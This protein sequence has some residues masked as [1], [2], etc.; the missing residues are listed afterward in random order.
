VPRQSGFLSGT[1]GDFVVSIGAVGKSP[2]TRLRRIFELFERLAGTGAL[3]GAR[4][5]PGRS[6]IQ[7]G[8]LV[9]SG[10]EVRVSFAEAAIDARSVIVLAH[11]LYRQ[12]KWLAV[13]SLTVSVEGAS[14][15]VAV[16]R[17]LN[18]NSTYPGRYAELPF[19]LIDED[20]ETDALTFEIQCKRPPSPAMVA[21]LEMGFSTWYEAVVRAGYAL[22]LI[23]PED[24]H[25]ET[26][27]DEITVIGD[28]AECS[29]HKLTADDAA[30]DAVLNIC[31]AMHE[32]VEPIGAV[33]IT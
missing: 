25:V 12:Q 1:R 9:V 10:A 28:V 13:Q 27:D 24:S 7:I 17:D 20:P 33:R 11:L 14:D 2:R 8:R 32:R 18:E 21:A 31:A 26:Y 6:R 29:Y 15:Y 22:A 5:P 30:V 23:P 16:G 19:E 4:I 3:C